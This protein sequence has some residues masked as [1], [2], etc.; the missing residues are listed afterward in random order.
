M[1]IYSNLHGGSA[2]LA[3]LRRKSRSS[4]CH[5]CIPPHPANTRGGIS[6]AASRQRSVGQ[7]AWS[8]NS[9]LLREPAFREWRRGFSSGRGHQVGR[10]RHIVLQRVVLA[11][12][13]QWNEP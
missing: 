5:Y 11:S 10:Q 7:S 3:L 6:T 1:P 2:A 13:S 4:Y 12:P 8:E 9:I